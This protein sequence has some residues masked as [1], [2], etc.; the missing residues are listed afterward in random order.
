MV[1]YVEKL[2]NPPLDDRSLPDLCF[3]FYDQMVVFDH[4]TK[5]LLVIALARTDEGKADAA[6][7]YSEACR[8]VDELVSRLASPRHDLQ[9][10]DIAMVGEPQVPYRS[11]I[12]RPDFEQAVRKCVE[13]IRA[14]DIFQVVISQRLEVEI[15]AEPFEIYRTLR[16]VNPSPFMFFL[17]TSDVTLVGS[18][19]EIMCRVV[20]GRVTVRPWQVHADAGPTRRKTS[21]WPPSCSLTRK[22]V[23]NTS[24]WSTWA[25]TISAVFRNTAASSFPT[26]W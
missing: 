12:R 10:T 11:N 7:A 23:P 21:A 25:A 3:A 4:I 18:S 8:R 14:G 6:A 26:S 19:P 20:D 17:R 24:C 15:T 1:R 22:S 2:P 5:T 13:Y 9:L 16:V